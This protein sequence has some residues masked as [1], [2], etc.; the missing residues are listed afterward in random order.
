MSLCQRL[1][2]EY[3]E[4]IGITNAK[5]K[6]L[7][8][9][10]FVITI[11]KYLNFYIGRNHKNLISDID[12]ITQ[13]LIIKI[14]NEYSKGKIATTDFFCSWFNK[15]IKNYIL[16]YIKYKNRNKRKII[17][18][19]SDLYFE[20]LLIEDLYS[21][22]EFNKETKLSDLN[23]IIMESLENEPDKELFLLKYL[24]NISL[25]ELAAIY[26][27][28]IDAIKGRLKRAKKRIS[29]KYLKILNS[30]DTF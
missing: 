29:K 27:T 12:D 8:L 6:V 15:V 1:N 13:E 30:N 11:Q 23:D 19:E 16:N 28:T 17:K 18:Y 24:D 2:I 3:K 9:N 4:L 7:I 5:D 10:K 14:I 25:L 22:N 20:I 21:L 26:D